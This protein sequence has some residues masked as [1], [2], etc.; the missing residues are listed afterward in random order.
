MKLLSMREKARRVTRFIIIQFIALVGWILVQAFFSLSPMGQVLPF[1]LT[2]VIEA[3]WW[4]ALLAIMFVLFLQEYNRFVQATLEL[5]E[6][7]RNL[8]TKTNDILEHIRTKQ[9]QE[10]QH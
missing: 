2:I 8:R 6:A 1:A 4:I 3:V 7:N 10:E 9:H 5:E